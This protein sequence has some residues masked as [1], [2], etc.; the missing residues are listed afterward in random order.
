M[1]DDRP[2]SADQ[3]TPPSKDSTVTSHAESGIPT[4]I[5]A[6]RILQK[7]GEGGMG[8]VYEAEQENRSVARSR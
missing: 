6:Y 2:E 5:G 1:S 3:P 7:I 8:V 4:R